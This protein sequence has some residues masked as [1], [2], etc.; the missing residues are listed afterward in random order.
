MTPFK[1]LRAGS[2]ET[3]LTANTAEIEATPALRYRVF[4]EEL[5][6]PRG[7]KTQSLP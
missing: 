4:F 5:T 3:R 1:F 7:E 2:Q 6:P